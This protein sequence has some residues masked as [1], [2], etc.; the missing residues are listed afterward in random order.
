MYKQNVTTKKKAKKMTDY[1]KIEKE[2]D[3]IEEKIWDV[4]SK[5][6]E[7]AELG[8]HEVDSSAYA[9]EA[10]ESEGF[11]ISDRG[12]GGIDTSW[13]ATWGSGSPTLGIMVEFDALPGLG[14]DTKPTQ[15]PAPSGNTNGHG[16]GHNLICSTSVGAAIA[17][18]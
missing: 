18:K 2:V 14:N 4:A 15:T 10:L 3:A 8:Y 6:W 16:C 13:I 17:L 5:I 11:K 9:S 12:I 7:F 1:T